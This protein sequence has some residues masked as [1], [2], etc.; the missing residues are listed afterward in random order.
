VCASDLNAWRGVMG[1][2]YP[3]PPGA[4]GHET[5]GEVVE[6]GAGDTHD[7]RVGQQVTG[8]L[9]NGL[10]EFGLARTEDLVGTGVPLLGEPLGCAMNVLRRAG[11]AELT[12]FVGFGYLAALCAQ[13]LP[14][15]TRWIAL[16]RRTESR[17]LALRLGAEAA[18]AFDDV[19][20][21]LWD[22]VPLVLEVA[23]VQQTLDF[24]T[25]LTAY[26]GRLVIAGY[27]A[28]G[29]RTVNMQSWNWKGI[30]VINAHDRRPEVILDALREGVR[31]IVERG[32]HPATLQTHEFELDDAAAAFR[33]AEE[34]PT[35]FVKAVVRL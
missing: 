14:P 16:S 20:A 22:A 28:D 10:A 27:H 4:P 18:F 13:V 35:G 7:L 12:A 30:D 32:V 5:W 21:D 8:L 31:R 6:I 15:G 9:W 23:G 26:S 24:A 19:P 29:P 1:I 3:L 25:W 2:E 34:R 11:P 17:A 33:M